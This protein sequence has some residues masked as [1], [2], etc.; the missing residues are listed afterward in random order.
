MPLELPNLDDRTYEDL[1]A[2]ALRL[3]P[4]YAPEWTNYNPSDPGI[5]LIEM[6]AYLT[7]MLLYRQNRI[8]DD[9]LRT[10]L[11]LLNGPDWVADQNQDL[12]QEIQDAVL[13][14]RDEYRA[15]T[16]E[17]YETL[18]QQKFN[19]WLVQMQQEEKA[20]KL[21]EKS[22]K[23]R[24][25]EWWETT[26]LEIKEENLPSKVSQKIRRAHC[27]P[28]RYLGAGKE[29]EKKQSK[30]N[31]VS[32]LILPDKDSDSA[33]QLGPQPT[34]LLR[35]ALQGYLQQ[36]SILTTRLSVVGP[37]YT[38]VSAEILVARR[39]DVLTETVSNG[40]VKA[41]QQFLDPEN[42]PFGRDVHVSEVY[43]LLEK[44]D[45]IDYL[46][47][48][49]LVS[50]CQPEDQHC[51]ATDTIWN[52]QGEPIGLRLYDHY[53]P[54]NRLKLSQI[55]IAP[56]ANFL[57]VQLTI[58]VRAASGANPDLLKREI[59]SQ[60]RAFFHPLYPT[61]H[62]LNPLGVTDIK[63]EVTDNQTIKLSS[64]QLV[65]S[66]Y[67]ETNSLELNLA[68]IITGIAQ[69]TSIQLSSDRNQEPGGWLLIKAGEVIDLRSLVEVNSAITG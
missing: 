37:S 6:F 28:Q 25:K 64:L 30:P 41:M 63:I 17:D 60:T 9:N 55:V 56:S 16:A 7:E 2:E 38:P 43:E 42:W 32:V 67:L 48:V 8:T 39:S 62:E 19:I 15:V 27:V 33:N 3:I 40:I 21:L 61:I 50:E 36:R 59:K 34:T 52:D 26:N 1:V 11:R 65:D 69:V 47:D 68:T 44:I 10:F 35:D 18:S 14:L 4:N 20:D 49:L 12:A 58:K 53:L 46:T 13:N 54:V 51:L 5:T 45:G 22:L 23:D 31:Y 66:Q 29:E 57:A 24:C